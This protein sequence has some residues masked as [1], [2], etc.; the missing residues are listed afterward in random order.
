MLKFAFAPQQFPLCGAKLKFFAVSL[1]DLLRQLFYQH[2]LRSPP[3]RCFPLLRKHT[4]QDLAHFLVRDSSSDE[5]LA[6]ILPK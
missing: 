1:N 3:L 5:F 4:V 2:E 6:K